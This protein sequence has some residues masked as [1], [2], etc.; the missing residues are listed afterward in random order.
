MPGE[1]TALQHELCHSALVGAQAVE[2]V[3]HVGNDTVELGVLVA[4]LVL[5]RGKLPEVPSGL[6]NDVVVELEDDLF[7]RL[8]S[9]G[10]LELDGR[11]STGLV[12]LS[13]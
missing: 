1:V 9:D 5:A 13:I 7:G 2:E 6:G 12:G 10:D 3:A 11:G 8:S 4:V